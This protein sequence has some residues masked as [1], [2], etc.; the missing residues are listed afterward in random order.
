MATALRYLQDAAKAA[1]DDAIPASSKNAK[2]PAAVPPL[3]VYL[4]FVPD[5]DFAETF[6][7][8][9]TGY[10]RGQ[11]ETRRAGAEAVKNC[12]IL[13]VEHMASE[14]IDTQA[15]PGSVVIEIEAHADGCD[16]ASAIVSLILE[17]IE[18]DG[19]LRNV[20]SRNDEPG[21]LEGGYGAHS[22]AIELPGNCPDV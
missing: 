19:V 12:V 10:A 9:G 17:R 6:Q 14:T 20:I 7:A 1:L 21:S 3:P 18:R 2:D 16:Y 13:H 4:G 22:C 11:G 8:R 15:S 5:L